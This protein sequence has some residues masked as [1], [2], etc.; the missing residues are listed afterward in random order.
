MDELPFPPLALQT[1]SWCAARSNQNLVIFGVPRLLCW[2][3]TREPNSTQVCCFLQLLCAY[4]T[5]QYSVHLSPLQLARVVCS[6]LWLE[7]SQLETGRESH[8]KFL[9][10]FGEGI[11]R[12][13]CKFE[14]CR[15]HQIRPRT[16]KPGIACA[17]ALA[18]ASSTTKTTTTDASATGGGTQRMG[19]APVDRR[20]SLR[21]ERES[22]RDR[23]YSINSV[24]IDCRHEGNRCASNL[25]GGYGKANSR[26]HPS[27][28]VTSVGSC[29][30]KAS[31]KRGTC[32]ISK[33]RQ[34]RGCS[35]GDTRSWA[36]RGR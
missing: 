15:L 22:H 6:V 10:V 35:K 9:A 25:Q 21:P 20:R 24:N 3:L 29:N 2:I 16:M 27:S 8:L 12:K 31:A 7:I 17:I 30:I 11:K 1:Y 23:A 34:H 18:V 13:H 36:K 14:I 26:C 4:C 5:V 28:F 33:N 32:E 19:H